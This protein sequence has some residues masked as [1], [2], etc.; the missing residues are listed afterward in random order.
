MET[1]ERC[2]STSVQEVKLANLADDLRE[3]KERVRQ[4]ESTLAR[5]VMLLLANLA[6]VIVTLLQQVVRP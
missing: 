2:G 1:K 3:L 4:L 6:A 5:G